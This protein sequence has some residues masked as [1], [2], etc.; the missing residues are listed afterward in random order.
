METAI[1]EIERAGFQSVST[2]FGHKDSPVQGGE[3][4]FERASGDFVD[5]ID[6]FFDKY[7]SPRFQVTF[8]RRSRAD[9]GRFVRSGKLVKRPTQYY[10]EWGKPRWLPR[11]LWSASQSRRVVERVADGID[12]V[13]QFLES[14]TRGPAISKEV[15]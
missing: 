14:G 13:L 6:L 15:S 3:I 9:V 1:P 10:Y 11:L 12:Q 5:C 7:A 2:H 4:R 8:S